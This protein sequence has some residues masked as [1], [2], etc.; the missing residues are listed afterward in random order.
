MKSELPF[1]KFIQSHLSDSESKVPG[2]IWDNIV[3]IRR[4]SRP[5]GFWINLSKV[6]KTGLAVFI[7][8]VGT[9]TFLLFSRLNS[10]PDSIKPSFKKVSDIKQNPNSTVTQSSNGNIPNISIIPHNIS[11]QKNG[12][13]ISSVD[14]GKTNI[15]LQQTPIQQSLHQKNLPSDIGKKPGY[16]DNLYPMLPSLKGNT[17]DNIIKDPGNVS[18]A[19][20]FTEPLINER[21]PD[22][23]NQIIRSFD[24]FTDNSARNLN[25]GNQIISTSIKFPNCPSLERNAAGNKKYWEI[26]G[27]PDYVFNDYKNF[28]DT[29]SYNYLQKRKASV[30]FTSAFSA[31]IRYTKVFDNGMAVRS[32]INFSQVNEIF[33]YVNPNELKFVT[34]I[35]KRIVVRSPGDT[36]YFNDTL[37][38]QQNVTH[39][40]TTYNHSRSIDIPI[41]IGYEF[42]NGKV[43]ANMNAGVIINVYSWYKGDI[44]DASYQ[45]ITITTGKISSPYQYKTNIGVGFLGSFT[46]YYKMTDKMHLLLEPFFRYNLSPMSNEKLNIQQKDHT[47]GVRLGMR[48]NLQ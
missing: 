45:P 46:L 32:G 47:A 30:Q 2:R 33:K 36:L 26:Y 14:G 17:K 29:A 10:H 18:E 16:N 20:L 28:G 39:V 9:G 21:R 35:T 44:L 11:S 31:G 5:K 23:I 41:T 22:N 25:A 48:F 42:G 43:H 4:Q 1:D 24:P 12:V 27:G 13:S 34:V 38:Y 6:A 40:K 3:A 8:L 19:D 15:A 37:Q 7:I